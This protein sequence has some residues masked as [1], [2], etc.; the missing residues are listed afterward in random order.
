MKQLVESNYS[1]V[2]CQ[3]ELVESTGEKQ[4]F[5]TGTFMQSDVVN[6]NRRVYP[7]S[8]M[9][10][11]VDRYIREYVNTKRAV[12]ELNHPKDRPV[13]DLERATHIIE[14]IEREGNN[15]IGKARILGT[16]L[17]KTV[18]A[19]LEGG[20]QIGVSSRGMG[21]VKRNGQGINEVQNDF[22]MNAVDIV[23]QPSAPDAFVEGLME[24][25]SFIWDTITEDTE[26]M[27]SLAD[28]VKD[29][30]KHDLEMKKVRVFESFIEHLRKR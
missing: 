20:V 7:S 13:T 24:N 27:Q 6:R 1:N 5:I 10:E 30:N 12:G 25:E 14:S 21:S 11:A 23:Y 18:S 19:L 28:E 15:Y 17:G 29:A 9:Q 4:L 22:S 26:F 2:E 3:E 16:P 8:V